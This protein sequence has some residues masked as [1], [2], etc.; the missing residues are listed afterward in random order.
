VILPIGLAY[1]A[2][3]IGTDHELYCW[4]PNVVDRPMEEFSNVLEKFNPD[5]VGVSFRNVDSVFSFY[6]RSYYPPFISM[7][8]MIKEKAPSCKLVVG[9]AGFS[10]FSREI[11][12]RNL[13]IDFGV[14]AEGEYSFVEL[15]ENFDHPE[16]VK[17]LLVRRNNEVF[18]TGRGELVDFD[19]LPPPSREIFNLKKYRE[20]PYAIGVQS[21]R[22]CSFRCIYCLH[23]F[24]MGSSYRLRS[25]KKVVDEIEELINKHGINSF[26]FV[27]PVFN[28]PLDHSRKICREIIRRKLEVRWEAC[29][30]PDFMNLAFMKEAIKAGCQL[31]DFSPDGAS[32]GAMHVLGKDLKVEHVERVVK[33]VRRVG[34]AK[35]AFEFLYDI[36]SNNKE[37]VLG[38]IRLFPK[39]MLSCRSKLQY[40]TL[41][42]MRIYPH[43]SLYKIALRQGK[44]TADTDLLY[45]VH[46]ELDPSKT[47]ES[48]VPYFLR[49]SSA[50][51][52]ALCGRFAS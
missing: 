13:E 48:I 42:R 24:L 7:L 22:G 36:P 11:M 18:F 52:R 26:Y 20:N 32:N 45:P 19:R 30:R 49:G 29:F 37:H 27:D 16:K 8:K 3:L 46:Y 47:P 15:L 12:E 50:T 40:L 38:L 17:N 14:V 43:T 1:I 5:V 44:I 51:F 33:L 31:F 41:T 10:I 4:D 2:S 39:I 23:G 21:K 9:G 28:V 34:E 25:P 6:P 35:V